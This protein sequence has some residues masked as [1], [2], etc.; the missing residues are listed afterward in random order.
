[1]ARTCFKVTGGHGLP[2]SNNSGC[3]TW[4]V[5][6][7]V[8]S[9][10][11]KPT[12]YFDADPSATSNRSSVQ[13]VLPDLSIELATDSGVF[14]KNRVDPGSKLLLLDGPPAVEGDRNLADIGAGYGPIAITIAKRNPDATVW[15]VE[16]NARARVLCEENA[17]TA[18]VANIR[19]V[20][21][22][23]V[24]DD[25]VFDR[26]WS[27]PPIR[28]GKAAL[29]EL[30]SRWLTRLGD[31]GSAHLVVQK[32]LGS[33]SLHRW[34]DANGWPT[35]RR[36]SRAGYRLLDVGARRD[37]PTDQSP[38]PAQEGQR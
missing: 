21:P 34:M 29:Q 37:E 24:P 4:Q 31:D 3:A 27:N 6:F 35:T 25:I 12:Q 28:I 11:D 36:A 7:E 33:D 16:V 19:V 15:A 22:D 1:M 18:G 14:A 30:L 32:H 17:Q 2:A 13:L 38:T 5:A 8:V 20:E 10:P 23:G 9:Q 26:I